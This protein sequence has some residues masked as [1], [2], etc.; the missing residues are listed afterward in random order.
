MDRS[1]ASRLASLKP[2]EILIFFVMAVLLALCLA[3]AAVVASNPARPEKAPAPSLA[4]SL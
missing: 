3:S 1:S 4:A 2:Y